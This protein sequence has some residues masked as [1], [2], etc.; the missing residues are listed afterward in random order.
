[1]QPGGWVFNILKFVEQGN[2]ATQ[3]QGQTGSQQATTITLVVQTPLPVFNCPT[4][5]D[6]AL[7]PFDPVRPPVNFNIVAEV[8]KSDYAVN[9]GDYACPGGT[10]PKSLAAGDDPKYSWADTRACSG[11]CYLRSEVKLADVRDGTSFTYLIGEK[12]TTTSTKDLGDDQ[13]LY[14][15]YDYDTYRWGKPNRPPVPD[16]GSFPPDRF[17]SAHSAV[18]NFV[19]CDGSV[20]AISY[21]ID[22]EVN[23]RL[24]NRA[25]NLPVLDGQF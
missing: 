18:C 17:G 14:S 23:R 3:G 21:S 4:R 22:P 20:H 24:V 16:G 1:M 5:R 10:G 7:A 9:A 12:W 8:A 15:G 13:T 25:D 6:L 19:F 2:L 11:V